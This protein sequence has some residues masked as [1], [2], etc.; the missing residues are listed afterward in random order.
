M[1]SMNGPSNDG[2]KDGPKIYF[3]VDTYRLDCRHA[4]RHALDLAVLV[5]TGRIKR[6]TSPTIPSPARQLL[7]PLRGQGLA[8]GLR[9][10]HP[11]DLLQNHDAGT[12]GITG[13]SR[14]WCGIAPAG[15]A[16]RVFGVQALPCPAFCTASSGVVRSLL[17][18]RRRLMISP[19]RGLATSNRNRQRSPTSLRSKSITWTPRSSSSAAVPARVV[20]S[21]NGSTISARCASVRWTRPASICR[22]CRIRS[23]DCR[24][25][26]P[27]PGRPWRAAP[28][29]GSMR[30][31]FGGLAAAIPD[32]RLIKLLLRAR[33]FH[34]TLVNSECVPFCSVACSGA[35]VEYLSPA[36]ANFKGQRDI[37]LSG[38]QLETNCAGLADHAAEREA[39]RL[40]AREVKSAFR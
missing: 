35:L 40:L 2:V 34:A 21:S 17:S 24:R 30:Q 9:P 20:I 14:R 27:K 16:L 18:G 13:K 31:C 22:S 36:S 3:V 7:M 28:M 23:P 29:T 10:H 38:V 32:A 37:G 8:L 39:I 11:K 15:S 26:T 5:W 6:L 19:S 33:R 25:S 1:S 4:C 12:D